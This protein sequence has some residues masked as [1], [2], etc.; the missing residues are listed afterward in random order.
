LFDKEKQIKEKR[1]RIKQAKGEIPRRIKL[2]CLKNRYGSPDWTIDYKYYP[3]YD[4]FE[5]QD[6][7][8]VVNEKTPWD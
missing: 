2:V 4:F 8:T 7:F 6:G 1:E 3:Q 5:E